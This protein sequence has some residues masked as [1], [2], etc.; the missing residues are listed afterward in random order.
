MNYFFL[1]IIWKLFKEAGL[2]MIRKLPWAVLVERFLSRVIVAG[3]RKLAKLTTNTLDDET[4]EDVIRSL[5]RPDLPE[6]K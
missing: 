6:V 5:K 2:A 1:T 3:L 4:V